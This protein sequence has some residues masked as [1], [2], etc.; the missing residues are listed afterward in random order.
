MRKSRWGFGAAA[1]SACAGSWRATALA[2]G[3]VTA[4]GAAPSSQQLSL[5]LP[6]NADIVG[7]ERFATA[8]TTV[9]SPLYGDYQPIATLARRFGASTG[10]RARV[11]HYLRRIGATHV[12]IDATGL[13]ADAMMRVSVAQRMFGTSLARY[14][15]ARAT[16]FVAPA[17]GARIPTALSGAVTG[18]VGLDTRPVFGGRSRRSQT[19]AS[20][21]ARPR[22]S[23][24]TTSRPAIRSGPARR[25]AARPRSP[26]AASRR[27]ST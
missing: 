19:P 7:L 3:R 13:F 2:H 23:A 11:L 14:Q 25:P 9:G 22:S 27:T 26:T 16:R 24:P 15:S 5:V 20:S 1:L 4:L 18:V 12:K 10:E 8:V 17:T 21:R 6:L